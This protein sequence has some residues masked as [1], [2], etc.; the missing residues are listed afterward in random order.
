MVVQLTTDQA[1]LKALQARLKEAGNKGLTRELNK[2]LRA[3]AE[4][5]AADERT[6]AHAL[7]SAGHGHT[8]L[9]DDIAAGVRVTIGRGK[10]PGIRISSKA[11]LARNTARIRGWR[12]LTWGRLPWHQQIMAPHWWSI[13]AMKRK[14]QVVKD[15][16]ATVDRVA[17]KIAKG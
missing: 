13:T 6:A 14:P 7:P 8:G 1:K 15:A 10:V 16:R 17:K 12:H 5:I 2:A 9:R 4:P 11:R 3:S